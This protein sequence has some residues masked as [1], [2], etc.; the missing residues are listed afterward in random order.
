MSAIRPR[1]RPHIAGVKGE[2]KGIS[3]PPKK[4]SEE[5]RQR[6]SEVAKKRHEQGGFL[7]VPGR[8]RRK[9]SRRRVAQLVAEAALEE[10]TA[11]E[12]IQVFR[13]GVANTQPMQIRLKAA[14]AW[15]KIEHGEGE[16][17]LKEETSESENMDRETA[18]RLLASKLTQG[19]SA[20]IIRN[21]LLE[22]QTSEPIPDAEVVDD[23][24]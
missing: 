3:K 9:P 22:S 15:L 20:E 19:S 2:G 12:I 11:S 23:D 8:P 21:R 7:P 10:K 13:D 17:S 6:L 1:P 24:E 14:E 5:G 18:L 4:I 16:L